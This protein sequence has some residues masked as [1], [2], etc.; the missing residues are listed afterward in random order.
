M[1]PWREALRPSGYSPLVNSGMVLS[2]SLALATGMVCRMSRPIR[3]RMKVRLISAQSMAEDCD[4]NRFSRSALSDACIWT[5]NP[6]SLLA[7]AAIAGIAVTGGPA[8]R[9]TISLIFWAQMVGNPVMAPEP[10]AAPVVR[11]RVRRPRDFWRGGY[12]VSW[13]LLWSWGSARLNYR[14][15]G[16]ANAEMLRRTISFWRE[17]AQS[18]K[19]QVEP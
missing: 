2:Q 7:C 19:T 4:R 8:C 5:V 6:R 10:M 11:S 1:V 13:W 15:L 9:R 16:D 12:R 18:S 14:H 3:Y 17:I